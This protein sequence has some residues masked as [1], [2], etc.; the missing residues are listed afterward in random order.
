MV[1]NA[2]INLDMEEHNQ[3]FIRCFN[4][5]IRNDF[6]QAQAAFS[7]AYYAHPDKIE[8]FYGML[9]TFILQKD[10]PGLWEMLEKE[11]NVS[12]FKDKI[13]NFLQFIKKNSVFTNNPVHTVL[14]NTGIFFKEQF[15]D[16]E[17]DIFFRVCEMLNP[18][19]TKN[20]TTLGEL[21]VL[22]GNYSKGINYFIKAA[23]NAKIQ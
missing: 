14:Y 10:L 5:I 17:T 11:K 4:L 23:N 1:K 16:T 8:Y 9:I 12:H 19:N 18:V 2:I 13:R 22:K 21:E 20:L 3:I 7:G 6:K 15:S